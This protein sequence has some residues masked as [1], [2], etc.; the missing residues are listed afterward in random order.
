MAIENDDKV[1]MGRAVKV[2]FDGHPDAT[3]VA[4]SRIRDRVE[5]CYWFEP[6]QCY[7]DDKPATEGWGG[8]YKKVYWRFFTRAEVQVAQQGA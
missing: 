6:G 1:L 3:H 2:S 5:P 7:L 4:V 8:S